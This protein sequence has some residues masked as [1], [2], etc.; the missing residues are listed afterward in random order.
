MSATVETFSYIGQNVPSIKLDPD[1][2]LDYTFD[3]T[4]WLAAYGD[5]ISSATLIPTKCTLSNQTDAFPLVHGKVK[6]ATPG[7]SL[8]CR[9]QT[10]QGRKD[11]RT[12]YFTV[13][14]R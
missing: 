3:W 13:K 14:D 11:D 8:T 4:A 5:T 9:I 2:E 1:A 12:I 6:E 10:A 7:A